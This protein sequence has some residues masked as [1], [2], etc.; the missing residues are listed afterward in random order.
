MDVYGRIMMHDGTHT[1]A[2]ITE[3]EIS[4]IQRNIDRVNDNE[5]YSEEFRNKTYEALTTMID[6]TVSELSIK[7][8]QLSDFMYE[9]KDKSRLFIYKHKDR[10]N[11]QICN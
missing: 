2:E 4:S 10:W 1:E 5:D 11:V 6:H 9:F 8:I 7:A 3:Y